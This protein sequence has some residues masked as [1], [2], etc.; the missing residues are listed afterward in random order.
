MGKFTLTISKL[1]TWNWNEMKTT[2]ILK[3]SCVLWTLIMW[4]ILIS[5]IIL[6][7]S[8]IISY[9]YENHIE[10]CVLTFYTGNIL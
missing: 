5:A 4:L 1:T 2:E 6:F 9:F 8:P 7:S 3:F 10:K